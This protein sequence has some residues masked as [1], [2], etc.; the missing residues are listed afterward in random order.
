MLGNHLVVLLP[1]DFIG[2]V[3][4]LIYLRVIMQSLF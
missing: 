3:A 4:R 1:D 2:Y